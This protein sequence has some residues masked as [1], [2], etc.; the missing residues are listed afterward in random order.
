MEPYNWM[1]KYTPQTAWIERKGILL[2]LAFFFIE[3]G[4]GMFFVGAFFNNI[5]SMVIGWLICAVLGG[6][7]HLAF[8][9]KPYRFWRM[10]FSSGWK[11]SWIS[12]G[13]TFVSLFLILGAIHI[14][15]NL[16]AGSSI[17]LMVD[18]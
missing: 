17:T 12:R 2:W 7:F 1:V 3:L 13:L 15:L 16:W 14:A 11:T 8:L 18:H 4:A 9:G 6:G 10:M 5:S